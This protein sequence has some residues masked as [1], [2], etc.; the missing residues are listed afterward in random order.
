[1]TS[2]S[3]SICIVITYFGRWPFWIHFFIESCRFN[4]TVN[5]LIYT[6]CGWINDCPPNIEIKPISYHDYCQFVS[7]KLAIDFTPL[8]AYKLCDIRP[9]YGLLHEDDLSNYDFWGYG[10]IDLIYG[11]IRRFLTDDRLAHKDV[12]SNHQTRTSGHLCLIRNCADLKL[13][14]QKIP[15]W[16]HK[17][18]QQQ[19]FAI[20]E[21]DFSKLFLRHKN[22]P[23]LIKKLAAMFDPWLKR[24]EFIEAY[25]TPNARIPWLDGSYQFPKK[26][27]WDN[28]V[29]TN[30][31]NENLEFLYFH[32][33]SWKKL[34]AKNGYTTFAQPCNQSFSIT[35]FGFEC[36]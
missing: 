6:D 18:T 5:W 30:D 7:A 25:S 10:D 33:Y 27:T 9:A 15:Y 4:P 14:F 2:S 28:G 1:M 24:A 17:F 20:D 23:E 32:F 36:N 12:Y 8:N 31:I 13:A 19:H 21:K 34:W 26:W 3:P 29:L 11:N 22:S 35:E 16:Q